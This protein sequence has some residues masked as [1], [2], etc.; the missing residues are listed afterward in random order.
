MNNKQLLRAARLLLAIEEGNIAQVGAILDEDD[1]GAAAVNFVNHHN[2]CQTPLHDAVRGGDPQLVELL[3]SRGANAELRNVDNKKP[4]DL[5]AGL[6]GGRRRAVEAVFRE[7][8]RR[9]KLRVRGVEREGQKVE[10]MVRTFVKRPG[11]A[12]VGQFYETKL[13]TMVLFRL[14]NDDRVRRFYLGNNLDEA[15]AFDDIVL[16][17]VDE[18][19][20]E[21]KVWCLQAKHREAASSVNF[22]DLINMAKKGGDFHLVKYF[23]SFLKIRYMFGGGG[24]HAIFRGEYELVELELII[25]TPAVIN[26]PEEVECEVTDRSNMFYSGEGG[27]TVQVRCTNELLDMFVVISEDWHKKA[28]AEILGK[29]ILIEKYDT[30]NLKDSVERLKSSHF[31]SD[32]NSSSIL[33]L[34]GNQQIMSISNRNLK[35]M[36]EEI[37]GILTESFLPTPALHANLVEQF[38]AQL[39]F[40]TEQATE[41]KL[42]PIVRSDI[43]SANYR[44]DGPLFSKLHDAVECWW[45]QSGDVPFQTERCELL[46]IAASQVELEQL[47]ENGLGKLRSDRVRFDAKETSKCGWVDCEVVNVVSA[48]PELSC[49]RVVQYLQ[50]RGVD[51]RFVI[52]QFGGRKLASLGRAQPGCTMVAYLP[53]VDKEVVEELRRAS[54]KLIVVT[55]ERLEGGW[56]SKLDEIRGLVDLEADSQEKIL[57]SQVTFQGCPVQLGEL[58]DRAPRSLIDGETLHRIIYDD[59]FAISNNSF[60]MDFEELK[61]CYVDRDVLDTRNNKFVSLGKIPTKVV[62][63]AAEPGMGKSTLLTGH[64]VRLKEEN[65]LKWI[66]RMNL[67]DLSKQFNEWSKA[68]TSLNEEHASNLLLEITSFD[69]TRIGSFERKIF[70]W[71]CKQRKIILLLDGFDEV[72]PDYTDVVLQLIQLY[73][74]NFT[75]KL[76]ITTR[77]G[78]TEKHLENARNFVQYS[79]ERFTKEQSKLFLTRFWQSKLGARFDA[80]KFESYFLQLLAHLLEKSDFGK[81]DLISIPLQIKMIAM[82]F[83]DHFAE[84]CTSPDGLAQFEKLDLVTLYERFIELQFRVILLEEKNKTDTS[85][86]YHAYEMSG[87]LLKI[88]I[89]HQLAAICNLFEYFRKTDLFS[90]AEMENF[91]KF[92]EKVQE[93]HEKTGIVTRIV[94]GK[95]MFVHRTYAEFFAAQFI[96]EKYALVQNEGLDLFYTLTLHIIEKEFNQVAK[97]LQQIARRKIR[98]CFEVANK[99]CDLLN[100]LMTLVDDSMKKIPSVAF[101]SILGIVEHSLTSDRECFLKVKEFVYEQSGDFRDILLIKASESGYLH[102]LRLVTDENPDKINAS[103]NE[104]QGKTALQMEEEYAGSAIT[105]ILNELD[106]ERILESFRFS[107]LHRAAMKGSTQVVSFLLEGGASINDATKLGETPLFLA[108]AAGHLEVVQTL[109]QLGANVN[110]ATV[111]SLTPLHVATQNGHAHVVRALL[112]VNATNLHDCSERGEAP[113]HSAIA[114][115]HT[116]I[117]LLLLKKG[118]NV[119][120]AATENGWTP[121]HFAVQQNLLSIAEILLERGA[122]VH[123]VSRDREET[124]LHLAVAAENL[125]M[126]QLLLGNG[127]D[128]DALDRCGKTG[129]NYAV[130]SKS[131]EIVTTLLKYGATLYEYDLGWTPLHEA[132]SVGSLELVELFL[133]QGVDVNRRARHGLTPLMLASFARQT[134]MV[135][136]LLDRGANVNLG[137]YGDDYMPLHCAAHKNCPEMIRLFAKK[138]A[139]VNCLAKSMGYTPLQEA[140]RNKAA[141]AV[142]L[143]LSLGADPDVGTMF[144]YTALE[145]ARDYLQWDS[146]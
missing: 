112:N 54:L 138:G 20:G 131:V 71:Y 83:Q 94:F 14:L 105:R 23:D 106:N 107:P 124:A 130:R 45:K 73:K 31:S 96:W 7:F 62:I 46:E 68:K 109:L 26:F 41:D 10:G 61:G 35:K 103:F 6:D 133:A 116:E 144:G 8:F 99:A 52:A 25:F 21:G 97:F 89:T 17:V 134:N 114:N 85:K 1:G 104:I 111:E 60:A 100:K 126:V 5:C 79:L 123:G 67:L 22:R 102:L 119:T 42:E 49:V 127:A 56:I 93:S 58:L 86:P 128:A 120:V 40:Y 11:T 9:N 76:R 87:N 59:S 4:L 12:A 137:T 110:T 66:I 136:L 55:R 47:H 28:I 143:L 29:L 82:M 50:S 92:L 108:C 51:F 3:L 145:M 64:A 2:K 91:E 113:L 32:F 16:R 118:A 84:F 37:E 44:S 19:G 72:S 95:P 77:S 135:K 140:I 101:A 53:E 129:L 80:K 90:D 132:A 142:H 125:A 34:F 24:E 33:K 75:A 63:V 115:G 38:F 36:S 141:K 30:T 122:P 65:P 121:L 78:G 15:G 88:K 43:K 81:D 146:L 39:R 70:E 98:E 117:V 27:K 74:R 57:K 13:L 139:D 69:S 18:G 48:T